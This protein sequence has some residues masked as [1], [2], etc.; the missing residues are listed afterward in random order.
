MFHLYIPFGLF[1]VDFSYLVHRMEIQVTLKI[2][3]FYLFCGQ[4]H[5]SLSQ[6]VHAQYL[7]RLQTFS[8]YQAPAASE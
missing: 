7:Q 3:G 6:L 8:L 5:S 1:A 4:G 2:C